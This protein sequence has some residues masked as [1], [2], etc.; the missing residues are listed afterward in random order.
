MDARPPQRPQAR[1]VFYGRAAFARLGLALYL[2]AYL[3]ASGPL[4]AQAWAHGGHVTPEQWA[5]HNMMIRLGLPHH[6]DLDEAAEEPAGQSTRWLFHF[7]PLLTTHTGFAF[8]A[9]SV[10]ELI[11]GMAV[12]LPAAYVLSLN[13]PADEPIPTGIRPPLDDRPPISMAV[14]SGSARLFDGV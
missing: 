8:M 9:S 12:V 1:P 11:V 3:V 2:L 13:Q 14:S 10:L 4:A 5:Y 7:A 6:H